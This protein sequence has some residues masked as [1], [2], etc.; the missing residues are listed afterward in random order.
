MNNVQQLRV[1]L[2]KT[3]EGLGGASIGEEATQHLNSVQRKLSNQI[4]ALA[5][6]YASTMQHAI[7]ESVNKLAHNLN[8][9]K[10]NNSVVRNA[11]QLVLSDKC[12]IID[13]TNM[14][15]HGKCAN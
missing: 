3:Y 12:R 15:L 9:H 13:V 2:E 5:G 7:E 11:L 6:Q 14:P 8:Q 4:D 1:Q 10:G